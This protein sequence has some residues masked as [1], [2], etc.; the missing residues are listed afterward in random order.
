MECAGE[1]KDRE[2]RTTF[3]AGEV[4]VGGR[5][6][7][8]LLTCT[9]ARTMAIRNKPRQGNGEQSGARDGKT[10]YRCGR[11]RRR[12][13]GSRGTGQPWQATCIAANG[14]EG[15][16]PAEGSGAMGFLRRLSPSSGLG[17][18]Q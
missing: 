9:S 12:R 17:L 1:Q 4:A 8:S 10:G 5:L 16:N 14:G 3:E 11:R 15:E 7:E 18:A 13:R 2:F 6:Q